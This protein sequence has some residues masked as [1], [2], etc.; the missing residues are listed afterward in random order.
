MLVVVIEQK[1]F[2]SLIFMCMGSCSGYFILCR[3]LSVSRKLTLNGASY[4]FF[5]NAEWLIIFISTSIYL[6]QF[7][8]NKDW[9]LMNTV[10]FTLLLM[11]R[12][13]SIQHTKYNATAVVCSSLDLLLTAKYKAK[14]LC[15]AWNYTFRK[16]YVLCH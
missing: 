2:L 9:Y 12:I 5:K 10:I 15:F 14:S 13:F 7:T 11:V 4:I 6:V 3:P 1:V 8:W 16:L